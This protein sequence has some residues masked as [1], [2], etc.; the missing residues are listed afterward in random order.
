MINSRY[1]PVLGRAISCKSVR[2][3]A[4]TKYWQENGDKVGELATHLGHSLDTK[5]RFYAM[6]QAD[7]SAQIGSFIQKAL[8]STPDKKQPAA[9]LGADTNREKGADL[10]RVSKRVTY[11]EDNPM[12]S[13]PTEFQE[14]NPGPT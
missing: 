6:S 11:Q 8:I 14:K 7:R 4:A 2:Q 13:Q 12:Q 1:K 3:R 10:K 5:N 9:A